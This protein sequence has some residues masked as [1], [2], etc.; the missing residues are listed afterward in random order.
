MF[1]VLLFNFVECVSLLSCLCIVIVIYSYFY[2]MYSYCHVYVFLVFCFCILIF[3]DSYGHVYVVL[4]L[5]IQGEHKV[6]PRLQT[7]IT[8]KLRGIKTYLFTII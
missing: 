5:H 8:R 1:C 6:F 3:I 2:V 4:L 7:F